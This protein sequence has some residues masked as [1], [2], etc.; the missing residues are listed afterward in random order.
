MIVPVV[1]QENTFLG[2]ISSETLV[3]ILEN[4]ASEDVYR[5]AALAPIKYPYFETPFIRLL[6]Q[7]LAILVVL[8]FVQS[9]S[10]AIITYYQATLEGFLLLFITML[11]S[12]GGN[13]SNQTSALV[14][15]GLATGEITDANSQKFLRREA[16]MAI[17]MG[18]SLAIFSFL[19]IYPFYGS[20]LVGCAVVSASLGL[21]VIFSVML[22]GAMPLVL[23]RIGLDPAHSAG[24]LLAT[25]IDVAGLL[26]YCLVSSF[27]LGAARA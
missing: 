16:L 9:L 11:T 22:G 26:I 10:T 2:V 25:L 21:I 23:K 27:V 12:T 17:V 18:V 13:A 6:S 4:E 14:I 19:R 15:Q 3:E 24:P 20:H 5:M 8:L 1:S 7:R